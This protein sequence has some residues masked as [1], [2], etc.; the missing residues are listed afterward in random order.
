MLDYF[1]LTVTIFSTK[2]DD[3]IARCVRSCLAQSFPGRSIQLLLSSFSAHKVPPAQLISSSVDVQVLEKSEVSP[4]GADWLSMSLGQT[5]SHFVTFL[6]GNDFVR[7]HMFFVQLLYLYDNSSSMGVSV[8]HWTVARGT[9][10]KLR[11]GTFEQSPYLSGLM[12]R[13]DYLDANT[14]LLSRFESLDECT[15]GQSATRSSQLGRIPIS[16]LRHSQ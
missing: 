7:N 8:D 9:D 4:D 10:E 1:D 2:T 5:T 16:F 6:D 11:R 12:W 15:L 3:N 13:K 14:E